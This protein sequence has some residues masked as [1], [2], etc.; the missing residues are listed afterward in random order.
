MTAMVLNATHSI[1]DWFHDF[2]IKTN[3]AFHKGGYQRAGRAMLQ[4]GY[5]EEAAKCFE[6][7]RSL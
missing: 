5:H 4:A 6:M 7:A 3:R 1:G 2:L